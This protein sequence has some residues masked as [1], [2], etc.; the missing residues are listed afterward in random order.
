MA[1]GRPSQGLHKVY[2][3]LTLERS[4]T[5]VILSIWTKAQNTYLAGRQH[6]LYLNHFFFFQADSSVL[7]EGESASDFCNIM[8]T[9]TLFSPIFIPRH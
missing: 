8:T 5:H 3:D 6:I 2:L 1:G 9:S 4:G 7:A